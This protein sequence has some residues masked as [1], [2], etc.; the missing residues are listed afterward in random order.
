M[1]CH[2]LLC[3]DLR[4]KLQCQEKGLDIERCCADIA[5]SFHRAPF[6]QDRVPTYETQTLLSDALL[7]KRIKSKG[8]RLTTNSK[9][10][11]F[12]RK[13]VLDGFQMLITWAA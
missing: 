6:A 10:W 8:R 11:R 4:A 5:K 2:L 3:S 7:R 13:Q 1:Q 12:K 9:I